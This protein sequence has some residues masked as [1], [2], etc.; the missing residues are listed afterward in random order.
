VELKRRGAEPS[1]GRAL[2]IAR[3][4]GNVKFLSSGSREQ[5]E[6]KREEEESMRVSVLAT[7]REK[8]KAIFSSIDRTNITLTKAISSFS[9]REAYCWKRDV[10]WLGQV[11]EPSRKPDE[12]GFDDLT[13]TG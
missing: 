6:R 8:R 9:N 13:V 12:S 4:A 5:R 10:L 7:S 2:P 3:S 1:S 11:A